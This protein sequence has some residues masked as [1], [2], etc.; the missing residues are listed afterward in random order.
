MRLR[1]RGPFWTEGVVRYECEVSGMV[2]EGIIAL[3][4]I[5]VL[6]MDGYVRPTH[7]RILPMVD[8]ASC[9]TQFGYTCCDEILHPAG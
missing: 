5:L 6:N 4:D 9:T 2:E 1:Q 7:L 3:N 8:I